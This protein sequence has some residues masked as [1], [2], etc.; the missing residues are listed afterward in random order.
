MTQ[1]EGV[2][3]LIYVVVCITTEKRELFDYLEESKEDM[4]SGALQENVIEERETNDE[5]K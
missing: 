5:F 4:V 3:G 1:K 2:R